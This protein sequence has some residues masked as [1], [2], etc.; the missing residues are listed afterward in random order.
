M[1]N[2]PLALKKIAHLVSV[3]MGY[4][5]DRAAFALRSLSN[6]KIITANDYPGIPT[7]DKKLWD[8]GRSFYETISRVQS[9]P[10]IGSKIFKA[11]DELQEIKPFY[12][13]RDLSA[14]NLQ[15]RQLYYLMR[16]HDWQRHLIESLP[17]QHL[18]LVCTFFSPAFA[19]EYYG[20]PGEIYLVATDTDVSRA[21]VALDPT[22]S[23]IKYLAPTGR[24][25]ERLKLYGVKERNIFLT[26]FPL[27]PELV[28]EPGSKQIIKDIHRRLCNL[29]PQGIFRNKYEQVLREYMGSTCD[30]RYKKQPV[31]LTF[32][33]GGAGAQANVAE[34]I[35]YSL[36]AR[37]SR[38]DIALTLVAG[39]HAKLNEH[40]LQLVK[41]QKLTKQLHKNL[42]IM[43]QPNRQLYFKQMTA[44]LR[45]TDIL[46]TK[47][48]EMSFYAGAGLPIIKAPSLGSQEDFNAEWL[49]VVGAGIEQLDPR[50]THEWL[51]D[52]INSGG[53]AKM[54]WSGFSEAPTY[55]AFRI[56]SVIADEDYPLDKLPLIV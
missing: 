54:A 1:T 4:G 21:W 36:S 9:V 33:V 26:G 56:R 31:K 14:P 16:H 37:I 23:R 49:R 25:V 47:P 3:N 22:Q 44:L 32:A 52:W 50:Y 40:F 11:F 27:P 24:V 20:Y 45:T 12:P 13:R 43:Y 46:W 28:G 48:S 39:T 51:F 18:P 2:R 10:V 15:V 42:T 30:V 7:S 29:D 35:L 17:N 53:L 41:S 34:Q 19:A 5:H 38:G 8:N 55:G 6:N